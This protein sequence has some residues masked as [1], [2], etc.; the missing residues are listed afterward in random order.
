MS[1]TDTLT[2]RLA[3]ILAE[4]TAHPNRS[5]IIADAAG[6]A[7][8]DCNGMEERYDLPGI[9]TDLAVHLADWQAADAEELAHHFER[10]RAAFKADANAEEEKHATE[11]RD[12]YAAHMHAATVAC[13]A[14]RKAAQAYREGIKEA[15][16]L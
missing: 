4:L 5:A 2:E 15:E 7:M 11:C 3:S 12:Y 10:D 1:S 6:D 14:L 16:S 8:N 9:I 13:K